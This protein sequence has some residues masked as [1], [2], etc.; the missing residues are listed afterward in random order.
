MVAEH[1]PSQSE[2]QAG[3]KIRQ[4]REMTTECVASEKMGEKQCRQHGTV[5]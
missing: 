3:Y 5:L 1:S 2:G 4:R